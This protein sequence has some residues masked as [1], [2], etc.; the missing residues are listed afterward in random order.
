MLNEYIF[1]YGSVIEEVLSLAW[2][3]A[4]SW[5]HDIQS[6]EM[7]RILYLWIIFVKFIFSIFCCGKRFKL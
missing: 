5:K 1:R 4:L 2:I 7:I 3:V 6:L